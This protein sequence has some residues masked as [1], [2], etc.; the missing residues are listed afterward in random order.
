MS[1]SYNVALVVEGFDLTDANL[2]QLCEL[3]PDAVAAAIG[4]V[5]TVAAP[6][7]AA[8]PESAAHSLVDL[9]EGQFSGARVVRLDQDLVAISDIADRTDRSRESIRLLVEGK[10]GPG[11][12]P[13]AIGTVGDAIRVWPWAIV[14]DWF[15]ESFDSDLGERGILPEAAAAVDAHLAA[16]RRALAG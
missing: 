2:E 3:V 11:G 1:T 5:V 6:M 13:P 14:V 16:R 4:G 12:F 10:R 7:E 15:S 8:D 9:L